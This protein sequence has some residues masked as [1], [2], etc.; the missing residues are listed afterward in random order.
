MS[1]RMRLTASGMIKASMGMVEVVMT[2]ARDTAIAL[3]GELAEQGGMAGDDKAG[4][5]FAKVY[6]PAASTTLDQIGFSAYIFGGTGQALMRTAQEFLIADKQIAAG[7][8]FSGQQPDLAQ[9]MGNPAKDCTRSFL[10]LG[11]E[12][13]DVVGDTVWHEQYR[14][15]GGSRYRGDPKKVRSVAGIWRHAGKLMERFLDDAQVYAMTANKSHAGQAAMAFDQYFKRTVGFGHPPDQVQEDEPLVA[16]LVAACHQLSKACEKYADHIETARLQ[17]L[18]KK[19]EPFR[20]ELP[21]D[22]PILGGNGD[23]GGLHTAIAGDPHIHRLGD[24][25]HALDSSQARVKL[26][27]AAGGPGWHPPLLPGVPSLTPVPLVLASYAVPAGNGLN[28]GVTARDPI[29]P[30]PMLSTVL[31]PAEQARFRA[32]A[33]SLPAGGFAGGGGPSRPDNA[34]QLRTAGYPERE[35]PLPAEA[36]GRSGKGLMADGLRPADGYAVEAKHVRK[37]NCENPTTFRHLDAVEKTLG[38]PPKLDA[39]GNAKFDPRRD[40][41]YVGDEKELSRYKA[42]ME[43]SPKE[44]RGLEIVTNDRDSTAYWQSMMLMTGVSGHTRYVP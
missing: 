33:N 23:D 26:P 22:S 29:P 20:I 25:A 16:N 5:A 37:P 8:G 30:D 19:A 12:L 32:W 3:G 11:K 41:M 13:P 24:V 9:G 38:T 2:G 4:R 44:L 34:Y 10:S 28:A 40:A 21:W 6:E 15:G 14:P 1:D 27:G 17:I 43:H 35:L 36:M 7:F 39:K 31:S 42:A 18:T